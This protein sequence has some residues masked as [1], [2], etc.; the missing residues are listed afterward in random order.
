MKKLLLWTCAL[1]AGPIALFAQNIT[2]SWQG[3]LQGPQGRSLRLIVKVTRADDE[4]LKAV[5]YSIDQ[6]GG[7]P[8]NATSATLQGSAFKMTIAGIGG[9]YE[10]KMN[11]DGASITGTW[12]QGGAPAPLV[13][14]RA[15]PETAWTIPDPPPPPKLMAADANPAFEVATIKPAN[16]DT[17]G[18]SMLVGRGGGNLFTTTNSTANDLITFAYGLHARQVTGGPAWLESEKFDISAKPDQAG[19]PN[20]TQ[21]RTMVQKMLADRFQLAFHR[22]KKELSAYVLTVSKTGPKMA[23]TEGTTGVL[24]GFGGR[25]PGNIIVRNATME[26][27]ASFLQ[28]RIL[29]R[30]VVDQT[31]LTVRYDFTLLWTPDSAQLAALGPNAPPVATNPDAP[32]DLFAAMQQQLGLKIE[33]AKTPVEVLVI[34]KVEKPSGN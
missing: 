21:L 26:E 33:S 1:A 5:L 14:A 24:P 34:D 19:V 27:F 31:G 2:G 9:T 25:G 3:T 17:P 20:L 8:I 6:A 15:T 30:P 4:S 23:K 22:D 16:P 10:G 18:A 32:P 28:S 11:A 7:Q 13:L 29:E 12:S